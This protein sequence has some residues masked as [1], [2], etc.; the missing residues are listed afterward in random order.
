MKSESR[1]TSQGAYDRYIVKLI[2]SGLIS[3]E[4]VLGLLGRCLPASSVSAFESTPLQ[5][6]LQ[7]IFKVQNGLSAFGTT[8][9]SYTR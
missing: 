8:L 1:L 2:V 3:I 6:T 4:V 7:C 5:S 9:G